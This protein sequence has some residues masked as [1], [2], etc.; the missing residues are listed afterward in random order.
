[1][2]PTLFVKEDFKGSYTYIA[3]N[4]EGKNVA[5]KLYVSTGV[6]DN[7][8]TEVTDGLIAGMKVISEGYNQVGDGTSISF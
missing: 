4:S 3:E 1:M 8:I 7:N 6:T 2:V 5:R